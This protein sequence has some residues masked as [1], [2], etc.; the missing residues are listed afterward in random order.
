[1]SVLPTE[2]SKDWGY[3]GIVTK[4]TYGTNFDQQADSDITLNITWGVSSDT[5]P[6]DG[7]ENTNVGYIHMPQRFTFTI[8]VPNTS[9][10]SRL[11]HGLN[12]NRLPFHTSIKTEEVIATPRNK[13]GYQALR[14]CKITNE[15]QNYRVG[16]L[17][18]ITFTGK[19]LYISPDNGQYNGN[20]LA[21]NIGD[22]NMLDSTNLKASL[23]KKADGG[24]FWT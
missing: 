10:I 5:E 14:Y 24:N 19:A 16:E 4:I 1:M 21:V 9:F 23:G 3:E 2:M 13:L 8:N 22:N 15:E 11:L 7:L 18:V 17:A 12:L 20:P 6:Y